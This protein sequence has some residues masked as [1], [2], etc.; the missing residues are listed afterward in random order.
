M[1]RFMLTQPNDEDEIYINLISSLAGQY[2]SRRPHLIHLIKEVLTVMDLKGAR[3]VIERDMGRTIGNTDI[4]ATSEK[5]TIYY[6]Q[7]L[8]TEAY[9]RFAKNRYP[10]PSNKLTIILERDADGN[11]EVSDTWIGPSVPPFPGDEHATA[12]SKQYWETHALAQDT[13][14]IQSK[15]ITADC[16]Y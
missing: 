15:T 14:S 3:I 6:A 4:V 11:Y 10:Q 9:W 8:K 12:A 2:V 13:Q 7:P 5:D 16:P 1:Y